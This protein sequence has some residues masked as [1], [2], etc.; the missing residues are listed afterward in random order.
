MF[1][2]M[3]VRTPTTPLSKVNRTPSSTPRVLKVHEEKI[4]VTVRVRP[5]SQ[6]EQERNDQVAWECSD[7]QTI[8]FMSSAGQ[9]SKTTYTFDK[10]FDQTCLTE[11]VYEEGA[12]DVA[13]SA[14]TGINATIFA[15]G[16]TNSGK[17]YTMQGITECAVNDIY[18]HILNTPE[19]D[20]V[21]KISALEIYNENVMDM[22]NPEN[23]S[24]RLLDD[25][26]KGTIVDKLVEEI[27]KDSQHLR[28]LIG[29]CEA[30]RQVGETA[31]NHVSSRSHQII[32]L[33][34]ESSV[35]EI[36]GRVESFVA[37]L[38]FVDLAGS[39]RA[40]I[41]HAA[42]MRLKEGC[43]INRSLLTLTTVIRKLSGKRNCHIPYRES[44]LTRILQPSL[45][46][47]ARTA[48]IC[49]MSP[50]LSHADQSRNTLLFATRAKEVT[51][52]AQ[53]NMV[54]SDKQL[55]KHLQKEVARLE[56][57]LRTPDSSS[58]SCSEVQLR[59]KEL[60]IRKM[61]ME[62][63]EMKRQR[64]YAQTQLYELQRKV[65][66]E[67]QG[68]D[69]LKSPQRIVKCLSFS[70]KNRLLWGNA[71]TINSGRDMEGGPMVA[72][73]SA[74]DP[75]VLM[76]EIRRH[77]QLQKQLGEEVNRALEVLHK[78]VACH[79]LGNQDAFETISKLLSEIKDM[80]AINPAVE[81]IE[82]N[83]MA[84]N[85]DLKEE[86][87]RLNSHGNMIATLE[88]QLEN[89]QK[90]IDRLVLSLPNNNKV[91][92]KS[93]TR[94][95]IKK[96]L[97]L[98]LS[99]SINRQ[100]VIR[101]PCSPISSSQNV[102][103]LELENKAPVNDDVEICGALLESS[104]ATPTKS[105]SDG[106]SSREGTSGRCRSSSV[107][108]RKM[109]KMFE[110]AAD[111]NIRSIKAYVTDLKERVAKLHYQKQIL[112]RKVLELETNDDAAYE[113][114][115]PDDSLA[116]WYTMFEDQRKQIV[117]L[118]HL[119]HV[120]IIRRTQFYLLF[121]GDPADRIYMEVE[122][123]RLTWLE[124]HLDELGNAS[125]ALLG[126]EPAFSV[127]SS[128][129]ALK[130]ERES[131]AKRM[132]SQLTA[133]EREM[134]YRKWEVP[135]GGRQRRLLLVNKLWTDPHNMQHIQE[136]AEIVAKLI[137]FRDFDSHIPKEM[138][139]LHFNPPMDK[140]SWFFGWN[141]ITD[142]LRL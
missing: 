107:N 104:K 12:K 113:D 76:H 8:L 100:H 53:V 37:S 120:S 140:R 99:S 135:Q 81:E 105:D 93:R 73:Q 11:K 46:G 72:S 138:F 89:V 18:K 130:Q 63:E 55:V 77:E 115:L 129:R 31:L 62:M 65:Q 134:L 128:I 124:Q 66:Q 111:E 118:W 56:A 14:L 5:L 79:H 20:F 83:G 121:R 21:V 132:N 48:I 94:T 101:S 119:C 125:P 74:I 116:S 97:P 49:T 85:P 86:I 54:V 82:V 34:I 52:S 84:S 47:N 131:L 102:I 32:R 15:Y 67:Q 112:V 110:T 51:N 39:E 40:S 2:K 13:L 44:K 3:T 33:T 22:L 36:S 75:V 117:M 78:E 26:E 136:S 142:F 41:T 17:T 30:Q 29:V 91:T 95:R 68:S 43:H 88:E 92:P 58:S 6:K 28:H 80:R 50:A 70:E 27:V 141:A 103:E 24:P 7:D 57:V 71:S 114:E 139:E 87:T 98:A 133:E 90:S 42:G 19:R 122:I 10:V 1:M 109:K 137:G 60:Q 45:G 64:D 123:R 25:P 35:R 69:R 59:E 96:M 106:M 16:Q 38:N 126:D 61:G 108:V 4:F 127:S 23:P 9:R